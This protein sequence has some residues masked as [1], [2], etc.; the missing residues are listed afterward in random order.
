MFLAC[1]VPLSCMFARL[2]QT[3]YAIFLFDHGDKNMIA[4]LLNHARKH[5]KEQLDRLDFRIVFFGASTDAIS[6]EPF[7]DYPDKMIHYQDLGVE[8]TVDHTWLRD[9]KLTPASIAHLAEKLEV[10]KKVWVGVSC[11]IF[12]QIV[13]FYQNKGDV[14]VLAFRDNPSPIGDTDYFRVAEEVQKAAHRVALPYANDQ[15]KTVVTGSGPIEDWVAATQNLDK[16]KM[17]AQLGLDKNHPIAVFAGSYGDDYELR[18]K[19]FL[20]LVPRGKEWQVL[21]MPH[22][23]F[24]GMVEKKFSFPIIGECADDPSKRIKNVEAIFIA[25]AVV[26]VDATSTIVFQA[27]ALKKRVL[28]IDLYP[29]RGADFLSV[30]KVIQKISTPDQC[31]HALR[32]AKENPPNESIFEILGMPKQGARLL[33]EELIAEDK[34]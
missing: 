34:R 20:D 13:D 22:P 30:K 14:A 17:I 32:T 27:N 33:W 19:K 26:T 31:A 23:R 1:C 10:R 8:E 28:Y 16:E 3:D 5:D 15:K 21:V 11:S 4:S 6:Q 7:C 2:I 12:E 9:K 18:F 29:S 25:D 24:K